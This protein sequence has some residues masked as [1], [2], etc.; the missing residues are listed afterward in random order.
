MEIDERSNVQYYKQKLDDINHCHTR[1]DGHT[2]VC[3]QKKA[4]HV[5]VFYSSALQETKLAC[6]I[7]SE[8]LGKLI[9]Y[10]VYNNREDNGFVVVIQRVLARKNTAI[11]RG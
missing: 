8:I 11:F 3:G 6:Q 4:I 1:V 10:C 2:F 9:G 7:Y 5:F